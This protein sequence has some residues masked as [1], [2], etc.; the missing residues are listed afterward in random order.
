MCNGIVAKQALQWMPHGIRENGWPERTSGRDRSGEEDVKLRIHVQLE[1]DGGETTEYIWM[2]KSGL[3]STFHWEWQ[4]LD[5]GSRQ[6]YMMQMLNTND[7]LTRS[8]VL[9]TCLPAEFETWDHLH[10]RIPSR[11]TVGPNRNKTTLHDCRAFISRSTQLFVQPIKTLSCDINCSSAA[12]AL[13]TNSFISRRQK[14]IGI[15]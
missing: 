5:Q 3:R 7:K 10:S 14:N 6:N 13:L 11:N 15:Q 4:G 8:L 1:E 9:W 12:T 2:E